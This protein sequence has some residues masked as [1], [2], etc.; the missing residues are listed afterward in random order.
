MWRNKWTVVCV[1]G[2]EE[3]TIQRLWQRAGLDLPR[4]TCLDKYRV[5]EMDEEGRDPRMWRGCHIDGNT[6]GREVG[7]GWVGCSV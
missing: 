4:M 6:Q 5:G 1:W 7:A 2:R 3:T